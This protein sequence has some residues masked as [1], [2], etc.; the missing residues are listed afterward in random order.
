MEKRKEEGEKQMKEVWSGAELRHRITRTTQKNPEVM[1]ALSPNKST[2]M[3][4]HSQTLAA[5]YFLGRPEISL[6]I[7][8]LLSYMKKKVV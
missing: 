2:Q 4:R 1:E 3:E 7:F 6:E 8:D 5:G